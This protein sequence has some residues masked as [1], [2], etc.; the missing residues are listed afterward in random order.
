MASSIALKNWMNEVMYETMKEASFVY[1]VL[2]LRE[3]EIRQKQKRQIR[4]PVHFY[5]RPNSM[6]SQTQTLRRIKWKPTH[7]L[8][9]PG[10]LI[11]RTI[12]FDVPYLGIS[13]TMINNAADKRTRL[14]RFR[15]FVESA[16]AF[17]IVHLANGHQKMTLSLGRIARSPKNSFVFQPSQ[18]NNSTVFWPRPA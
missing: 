12:N 10:T 14:F 11:Y 18:D 17:I 7:I 8:H 4:P 9:F 15:R 5:V 2:E 16:I 13:G 1:L 3:N 6:P